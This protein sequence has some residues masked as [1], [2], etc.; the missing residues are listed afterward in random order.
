MNRKLCI[1][2][3]ADLDGKC[4]AAIVTRYFGVKRVELHGMNYGDPIPWDKIDQETD[5]IMVDF[6]LQPFDDMLKLN[7]HCADLTWID[8]HKT[9]IDAYLAQKVRWTSSLGLDQAACELV[10]DFYHEDQPI[11]QAVR[12]L[13]AYD[14]WSW[15]NDKNALYF[16][17]G[18]RSVENGPM[19]A[20]WDSLLC[21][22]SEVGRVT[23]SLTL[24]GQHIVRFNE[25]QNAIYAEATSFPL[26]WQGLR[27][28]VSNAQLTNSSLFDTVFD[29]EKHDAMMTFAFR[30]G[31]WT[32]GMYCPPALLKERGIDLGALAKEFGGGGHPGAAGFAGTSLPFTLPLES[33]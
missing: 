28:I 20:I 12:Y 14:T 4:S 7:N 13:G 19:G 3:D 31:Q 18:I 29:P 25:R 30:K 5:V 27:F 32:I 8:H 11:P 24:A 16:Q 22:N 10:W 33:R 2:H 17:Y 21:V 1:Y 15:E 9:A 26:K 23:D 6:C